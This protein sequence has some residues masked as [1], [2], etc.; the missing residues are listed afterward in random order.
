MAVGSTRQPARAVQR[1]GIL[2]ENALEGPVCL[3]LFIRAKR[4]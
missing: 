4:V 1:A 2:D 3:Y